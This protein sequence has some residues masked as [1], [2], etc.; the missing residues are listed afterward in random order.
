[1][2]SFLSEA[3]QLL[4]SRQIYETDIL[5]GLTFFSNGT[6]KDTENERETPDSDKS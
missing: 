5:F 2:Y 6:R 4:I 1:M 3:T